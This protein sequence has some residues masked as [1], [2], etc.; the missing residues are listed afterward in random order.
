LRGSSL[1]GSR[2]RHGFT[3]IEVIA[4]LVI[5]STGVILAASLSR[6]LTTQL[7][8]STLRSEVAALGRQTL[9]SLAMVPYEELVPGSGSD[10]PELSSRTFTREWTVI[11][12]GPRARR[13]EV[14]IVPPLAGGP[15]FA[16]TTYA[17]EP[18]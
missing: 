12:D 7:S 14:E 8:H 18:W 3:L 5:F 15:S 13:I 16:G 10:S 2:A 4:A 1:S 17:V 11:Q 9:D 6:A